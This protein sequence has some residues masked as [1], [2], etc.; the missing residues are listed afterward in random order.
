[1]QIRR[2]KNAA[3]T[4][5]FYMHL[6]TL[7]CRSGFTVNCCWHAKVFLIAFCE[8]NICK[9][10]SQHVMNARLSIFLISSLVLSVYL[11]QRL[12]SVWIFLFSGT[13][14]QFSL[15]WSDQT[16]RFVLHDISQSD[17]FIS[18]L[19]WTIKLF[20]PSDSPS[21]PELCHNRVYTGFQDDNVTLQLWNCHFKGRPGD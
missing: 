6:P 17:I 21:K 5:P 14:V 4:Y 20:L 18:N 9:N 11:Q 1:M 7:T 2:L 16:C 19:M 10:N 8:T 15:F 3:A 13:F 12:E